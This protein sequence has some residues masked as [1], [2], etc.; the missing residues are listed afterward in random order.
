MTPVSFDSLWSLCVIASVGTAVACFIGLVFIQVIMV[1]HRRPDVSI[2]E[3]CWATTVLFKPER[4]TESGQ[5][6]RRWYT[7]ALVGF[8]GGSVIAVLFDLLQGGP[9]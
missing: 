9:G 2:L 5:L 4:F 8:L 6:L 1:F 3:G 7:A